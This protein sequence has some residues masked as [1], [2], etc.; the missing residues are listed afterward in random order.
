MLIIISNKI[1]KKTRYLWKCWGKHKRFNERFLWKQ[2]QESLTWINRCGSIPA[3]DQRKKL[4]FCWHPAYLCYEEASYKIHQLFGGQLKLLGTCI[5]RIPLGHYN[6]EEE[7]LRQIRI[8]YK[9][10]NFFLL[11]TYIIVFKLF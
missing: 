6:K 8:T 4:F 1:H 7:K 10:K 9:K 3:F 5:C 11:K 2:S